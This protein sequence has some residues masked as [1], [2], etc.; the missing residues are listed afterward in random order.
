MDTLM[1]RI[2]INKWDEFNPK[3]DQKTY[4]WFRM[5]NNLLTSQTLFKLNNDQK[6]AFVGILCEASKKNCD[7]IDI[8]V[9]WL[10]FH[11]KCSLENIEKMLLHLEKEEVLTVTIGSDRIRTDPS[12]PRTD[13]IENSALR[14]NVRTNDTNVRTNDTN[15]PDRKPSVAETGPIEE[16]KGSELVEGLLGEIS[17]KSQNIWVE[18]YDVEFITRE[19]LSMVEW[20]DRNPRKKQRSPMGKTKAAT[21]WLKKNWDEHVNRIPTQRPQS[22][23]AQAQDQQELADFFQEETA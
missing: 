3:K 11:A 20:Y 15:R 14:T 22:K 1:A 7:T 6:W 5:Q 9:D 10:S 4:T 18:L 21:S 17:T 8:D 23:P 12:A 2:K 19:L 16:L 13:P